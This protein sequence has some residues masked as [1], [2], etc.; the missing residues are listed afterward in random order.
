MLAVATEHMMGLDIED[1]DD[2]TPSELWA[3]MGLILRRTRDRYG[4]TQDELSEITGLDRRMISRVEKGE[5]DKLKHFV[6]LSWA[7]GLRYAAV[8]VK[9]E[10][11]VLTDGALVEWSQPLRDFLEKR[12]D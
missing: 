6:R 11:M 12:E 10:A 3:A 9:A 8:V 1:E 7:L 4:L 5:S 2:A